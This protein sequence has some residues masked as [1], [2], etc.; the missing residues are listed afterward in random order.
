[1]T[2]TYNGL[3]EVELRKLVEAAIAH[4][5]GRLMSG[6]LSLEDYR[7]WGGVVAGLRQCLELCDEANTI[8]AKR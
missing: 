3:F 6:T 5:A 2:Q 8:M 4:N 1:M 7:R